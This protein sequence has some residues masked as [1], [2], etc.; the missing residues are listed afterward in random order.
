MLGSFHHERDVEEEV[1][2][3]SISY[4]NNILCL[5][6]MKILTATPEAIILNY[7]FID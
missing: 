1:V 3:L 6:A 4:W 2:K 5:H 7:N